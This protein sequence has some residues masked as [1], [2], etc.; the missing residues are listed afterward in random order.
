MRQER[1]VLKD[2]MALKE[3]DIISFTS[4]GYRNIYIKVRNRQRD[5]PFY[6]NKDGK[7]SKENPPPNKGRLTIDYKPNIDFIWIKEEVESFT[8]MEFK[9]PECPSDP[10]KSLSYICSP[11]EWNKRCLEQVIKDLESIKII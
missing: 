9:M 11:I 6:G 3:G 4:D 5:I 8:A 2:F 10:T 1:L 7:W